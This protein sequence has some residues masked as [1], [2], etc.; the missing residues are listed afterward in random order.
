M[1]D[2]RQEY[3]S[4]L[5]D[6]SKPGTRWETKGRLTYWGKAAGLTAD[7]IVADAR[8]AGV[9]DR[10]ADIRRGWNDAHPQ[11]D[12]P[13]EEWRR[14][15]PTKPKAP[16]SFPNYVRDLIGDAEY[17]Q[18]HATPD[19]L[20]ELSP[21]L[22]WLQFHGKDKPE[23]LRAQ[24][25][26]FMRSLFDPGEI[27]YIFRADA[28]TAGKP[29]ENMMPAADWITKVDHGDTMPGELI[30]PNPFTGKTAATTAGRES[31]IAQGCLASFPYVVIEF[32]EM[33]LRLQIAF[34]RGMI[35]TSPLAQ[36]VAAVTYSGGKS[37]HALLHVGCAELSDWQTVRG[38]LR[39]LLA[40]SADQAYR[41]DE[42]AMRPRTGTRLPGV[43]RS[44]TGRTQH[45][46][47]LNPK[48][49]ENCK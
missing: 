19:W 10:D 34:W 37:L 29:D 8:A 21:C 17:A 7:E 27:L 45:L 18:A 41:A 14:P 30:V 31:Y 2:P 32:D 44:S 36:H 5:A 26:L 33:P 35:L 3:E 22:D 4:A 6:F 43:V 25:R 48:A 16:P 1:K 23:Y 11:G 47:Y 38:Q 39:G 9:T 49:K 15:M 40:T 28:P 13:K 20:R 12:R 24:T 46:L 42:Q